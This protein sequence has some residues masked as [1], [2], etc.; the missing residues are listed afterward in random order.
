ME[1]VIAPQLYMCYE[2]AKST[3]SAA[4]TSGA[5]RGKGGNMGRCLIGLITMVVV[6]VAVVA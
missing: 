6:A 5:V 1:G 2:A 3:S 4:S